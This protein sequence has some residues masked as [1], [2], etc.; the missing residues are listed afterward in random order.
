CGSLQSRCH[1][2]R[3]CNDG[4]TAMTTPPRTASDVDGTEA[5]VVLVGGGIMSATLGSMLAGLQ[6]DWRIVLLDK[7]S[8]LASE[9]SG[10]WN[11]AGTGHSGFCELNYTPDPADARKPVMI[12]RQSQL[13]RQWWAYLADTGQ[14][15]PDSFIHAVPHMDVVFGTDDVDYLRRRYETMRTDPLFAG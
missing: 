12:A 2:H 3:I 9:S 15:D 10:P 11:N 8:S 1:G 6:P 14:I 13:S 4:T 7:A 5:D